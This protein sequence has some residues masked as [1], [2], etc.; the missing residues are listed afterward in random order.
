M[1]YKMLFFGIVTRQKLEKNYKEHRLPNIV[2]LFVQKGFNIK[3]VLPRTKV[4]WDPEGDTEKFEKVLN[5][6]F[7]R[8]TSVIQKVRINIKKMGYHILRAE[9]CCPPDRFQLG[10][11][12]PNDGQR[13]DIDFESY[14]GGRLLEKSFV[15]QEED[16]LGRQ[17]VLL[18]SPLLLGEN[19]K[20]TS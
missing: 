18:S 15:W 9:F 16:V 14:L 4:K 1:E 2:I 19:R 17:R 12:W 7:H 3:L 11:S 20:K 13:R 5:D 6:F 10:E 8:Q